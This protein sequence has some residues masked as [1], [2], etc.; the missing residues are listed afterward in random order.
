MRHTSAW[1]QQQGVSW[2]MHMRAAAVGR[3]E[4]RGVIC[5]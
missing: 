5:A 3:T 2:V 1:L 4:V